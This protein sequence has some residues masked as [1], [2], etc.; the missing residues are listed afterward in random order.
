MRRI[1][2]SQPLYRACQ[3]DEEGLHEGQAGA[4]HACRGFCRGEDQVEVVG[5]GLV[6]VVV[7]V[8]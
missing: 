3:A 5:V 4:H 8:Y 6:E 7:A 2:A 1:L